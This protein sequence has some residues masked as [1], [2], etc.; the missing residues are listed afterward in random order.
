MSPRLQI[1]AQHVRVG[2][3]IRTSTGW[4]RVNE[5]SRKSAELPL[6]SRETTTF[7]IDAPPGSVTSYRSLFF[8]LDTHVEVLRGEGR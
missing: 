6:T 2:D 4:Q 1:E 8:F 7:K 5:I 3:L